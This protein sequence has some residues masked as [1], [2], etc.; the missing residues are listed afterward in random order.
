M[1][2]ERKTNL[3]E[4]LFPVETRPI[5]FKHS[6]DS[7]PMQQN[8]LFPASAE[9]TSLFS[10]IPD[11]RAIV[12]VQRE[13]V[14]AVVRDGY[15]LITNQKAITLGE[16]CFASVFTET[17][18]EGME[19]FNIT[20]PKTRS[21]CHIDYVHRSSIFEPWPNDK[22][23]PFL[24]VTNSYNRTK[25]LRFDL[26][27]C[28]WICANGMIFGD[29]SITFRYLHTRHDLARTASF[30]TN[31]G[32]LKKLE[33]AFIEKLHNLKRFYVPFEVMLPLACKTFAIKVVRDD[34]ERPKRAAQL[35]NLKQY[36]NQLTGDYFARMGPNGYAALNVLTDFAT[37]PRAYIAPEAM[38]DRLQRHSA[39]WADDF[40]RH[41]K[42]DNFTFE[43]YLGE[44]QETAQV[45]E[46]LN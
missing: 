1:Q 3:A 45:L 18:S 46:T 29:K 34:L 14:F 21:F 16:Q 27:F 23:S 42:A 33:A 11:F 32:D 38:V 12:D 4:V 43:Q 24:R 44:Y 19:V 2:V 15:Q 13:H 31:L 10:A 6:A 30:Q 25:P 41:I 17:L 35:A 20:M 26:G 39:A 7:A 28:R 37:R 9:E 36:V 8:T 5:F 40:I 22:W